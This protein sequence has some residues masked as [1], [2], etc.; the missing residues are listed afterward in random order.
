[1]PQTASDVLLER[2]IEWGV[3][4]TCITAL[5]AT[6]R[7]VDSPQVRALVVLGYEDAYMLATT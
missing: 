5:E 3:E 2:L 7:L 1:M 4:S 6:T